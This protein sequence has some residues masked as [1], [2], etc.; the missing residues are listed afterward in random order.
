[1]GPFNLPGV[2]IS[3]SWQLLANLPGFLA[4]GKYPWLNAGFLV[5]VELFQEFDSMKMMNNEFEKKG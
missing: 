2:M 1:M 4:P 5:V 3:C